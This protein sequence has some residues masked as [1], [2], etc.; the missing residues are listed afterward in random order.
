MS[1][2]ASRRH[3]VQKRSLGQ[4]SSCR[5]SKNDCQATAKDF[6][7]VKSGRWKISRLMGRTEAT[8]DSGFTREKEDV[9]W[10]AFGADA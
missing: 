6:A 10:T 7:H 9:E 3:W 2:T 8:K 4:L 5:K 1:S